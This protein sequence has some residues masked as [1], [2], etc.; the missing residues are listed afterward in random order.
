MNFQP[1]EVMKKTQ[2]FHLKFGGKLPLT[3]VNEMFIS[4]EKQII[5]IEY[6]NQ[7]VILNNLYVK[8][9]IS[10]ALEKNPRPR[11]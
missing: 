1:E 8:V 10:Y 11:K 2:I 7:R 5:N 6:Q 4:H 9:G 3:L